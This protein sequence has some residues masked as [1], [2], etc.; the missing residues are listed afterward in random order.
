MLR[1]AGRSRRMEGVGELGDDT[2]TPT[3]EQLHTADMRPESRVGV[4]RRE[5]SGRTLRETVLESS[6]SFISSWSL[7]KE[8]EELRDDPQNPGLAQLAALHLEKYNFPVEMMICLPNGT[9][10]SEPCPLVP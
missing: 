4:C 7:V 9:V 5:S 10:V 1:W 2:D 3:L 8:L 6:P